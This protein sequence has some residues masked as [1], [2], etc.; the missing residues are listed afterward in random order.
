MHWQQLPP[1]TPEDC[2]F[3]GR[4][5]PDAAGEAA[6]CGLVRAALPDADDRSCRVPRPTCVACCRAT[7]ATSAAWNPVVGSLVYHAAS[8]LAGAGKTDEAKKEAAIARALGYHAGMLSLAPM[9][10]TMTTE[11][12]LLAPSKWMYCQVFGSVS[13][14]RKNV[15]LGSTRS[16]LGHQRLER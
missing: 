12:V 1:Q 13:G 6:T 14:R 5:E 11:F 15:T 7:P 10:G 4:A 8:A 3:Q 9:K 16:R 2:R